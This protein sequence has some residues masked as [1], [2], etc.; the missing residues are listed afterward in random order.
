MSPVII[1][2]PGGG[3]GRLPGFVLVVVLPAGL[4]AGAGR[5]AGR[6]GWALPVLTIQTR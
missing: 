2:R 3:G 4:G 1:V 5:G 6:G